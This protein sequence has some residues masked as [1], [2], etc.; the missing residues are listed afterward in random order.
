MRRAL[1]ILAALLTGL[2]TYGAADVVDVAPGV[3]TYDR[4][5]DVAQITSEAQV[6]AP[7]TVL[8]A[9]GEQAPRPTDDSLARQLD[10]QVRDAWLGPSVG[11]VVRD[12][13]TG[14]VLYDHRGDRPMTPAS[15]Q[16]ILSAAAVARTL[17]PATRMQ[18]QVVEGA[19]GELVLVASGDTLLASGAGDP[20]ATEGHA[21]LRDLA[22]AVAESLGPQAKGE[23]LPLRLDGTY[24]AGPRVPSTWDPADLAAGYTQR[25]TMIGLADERPQVFEP[26]PRYPERSVLKALAAELKKEGVATT[27]ELDPDSWSEP[28]PDGAEVLGQVESAPVSEVLAEALRSS[29]NALTENLA[30]QAAQADGAEAST[31]RDV[32]DWVRATLDEA[33]VDMSGVTMV[34]ASGLS[35]GQKIPASVISDTMQLGITGSARSLRTVLL[36]LPV[37]GV[38]GTLHD[39]FVAEDSRP[40]AGIARAKTGTLTGISSLAGTTVTSD[41]R[42]LTYTI[43]ADKVPDTTGTLG[44]RAVLDRMVGILTSCGCR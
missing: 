42:V 34:D 3:L 13:L 20:G 23:K 22:R 41:G 25:V 21:G 35:S 7:P 5:G 2:V 19:K 36:E 12:A 15:T 11:M 26:S 29:D 27:P 17:D 30:R 43:L 4:P 33:G 9:A 8:P 39:R 6:G 24:A 44:A 28:A 14:D 16:K 40:A 37:A 32:A 1:P 31:A 10:P 38:S 18:T